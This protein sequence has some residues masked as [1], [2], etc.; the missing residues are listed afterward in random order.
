MSADP[1]Q[2][3]VR[4]QE[5]SLHAVGWTPRGAEAVPGQDA[6]EHSVPKEQLV[7]V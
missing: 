2:L 7:L 3:A 6:W 1:Q 4:S 5:I